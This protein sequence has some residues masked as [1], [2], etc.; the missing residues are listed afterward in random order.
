LNTCGR[1]FARQLQYDLS[2]TTG[3]TTFF[4]FTFILAARM[5]AS[6]PRVSRAFKRPR[7]AY[8]R[9][10]GTLRCEGGRLLQLAIFRAILTIA[11]AGLGVRP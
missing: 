1:I 6:S 7:G 10:H 9:P 5:A 2:T 8:K 3:T 11:R 4:E